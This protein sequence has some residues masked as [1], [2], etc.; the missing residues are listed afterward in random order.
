MT[1]HQF[2]TNISTRDIQWRMETG[3]SSETF[4]RYTLTATLELWN[5]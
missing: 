4:Y 1:A 5:T 3:K 2:T